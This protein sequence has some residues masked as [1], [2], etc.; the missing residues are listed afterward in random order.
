VPARLAA[1]AFCALAA[2]VYA[3]NVVVSGHDS[4]FHASQGPFAAGAQNT[5]NK[6]LDFARNGN[7]DPI[8]Y[9]QTSTINNNLGDHTDSE[10]GLIASGY[11]ASNQPGKH[12]VKFDATSFLTADLSLYSAILIP[13]DHG[14]SLTGDDLKA[15]VSRT[16]DIINYINNGGGLVAFAED[17][18]HWPATNPPE[19]T[20]F[21]FLPFL[22]TSSPQGEFESGNTLTAFGLSLGLTNA[23]INSNFSHNIFTATGGMNVIDTDAGGE[24][25]SLGFSGLITQE[26]AV[27]EPA[28]LS[29]LAIGG[30]ALL[31]R[32][33]K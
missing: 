8:L 26:G 22:V 2:N 6:F 7:D 3:G 24:I 28:S 25:L 14:G 12:Y 16:Q 20:P 10:Q 18:N 19:A 15:I 31:M 27:P 1:A 29:L 11:S 23:D 32:R 17:G 21:G 9:I 4:D 33:R 5:I 30:A 13:S